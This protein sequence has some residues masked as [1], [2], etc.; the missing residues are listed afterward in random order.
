MKPIVVLGSLNTDLVVRSPR[1]PRPGETL[2]GGPFQTFPGG[3]GANQA[4]AIARLG[5]P[6]VMIGK[7][8]SDGF[9]SELMAAVA[10]QGVDTRG[11]SVASEAATGVA[12][13]TVEASGQNTIIVVAGANALATPE[14]VELHAE[15][16]RNASL[17]V[18]QLE[19]PLEAVMT[20]ASLARQAGVKVLLNPAPAQPLPLDL[21]RNVDLLAPNQV[22]LAMLAGEGDVAEAA[23]KLIDMGVGVMV[24]TLGSEGCYILG[25]ELEKHLPAFP[26]S[27]IDT[28]AAGDAFIGAFAVALAEGK[29][30]PEASRWGNAAG[31]IAATRLG[32][33]PSL[34]KRDEVLAL[35]G[36]GE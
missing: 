19:S 24:V 4:V 27:A 16:I 26:V 33:Q 21:L 5:A 23:R 14:Y 36:K 31:A 17:L 25:P 32:A 34:P 20:A 15:L 3:K 10:E 22:E 6:V 11:I 2:T 18:M 1:L 30:L 29:P 13:I 35:L 8:G 12:L 7:V 28:V 9:G